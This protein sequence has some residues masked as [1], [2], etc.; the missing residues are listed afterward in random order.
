[1]KIELKRLKNDLNQKHIANYKYFSNSL[2]FIVVLYIII[3]K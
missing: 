1:M 3:S 2:I